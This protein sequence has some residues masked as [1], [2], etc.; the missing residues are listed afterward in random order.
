MRYQKTRGLRTVL[1]A[2]LALGAVFTT[3]GW[4][5][6]APPVTTTAT[7]TYKPLPRETQVAA[8]PEGSYTDVLNMTFPM[9]GGETVRVTDQLDV[10]LQPSKNAEMDQTV[11][12]YDENADPVNSASSGV[13]YTSA[14]GH[15]YQWNVSLLV[16]APPLAPELTYY[17]QLHVYTNDGSD[18]GYDMSVLPPTPGETTYGTWLEVSSSNVAGAQSWNA[19]YCGSHG[20]DSTCLYIGHSGNPAAVSVF[21]GQTASTAPETSCPAGASTLLRCWTAEDDATT[22]DAAA[23]MQITSCPQG[24][25]SCRCKPPTASCQ[26]EHGSDDSARGDA[27]LDVDQLYPD[28]SVCQVNQAYSEQTDD[29]GKVSLTEPYDI[30]NAQHHRPLYFHLTAPV[31][32]TCGGSREFGID[33]RILWTGGNPV[34]LDNGSVNV[35]NSVRETTTT[36]PDVTGDTETAAATAIAT[37]GLTAV[38]AYVMATAPP[39][40][41]LSQNSAG[42]TIEPV[43]SPVQITVSAGQTAVPA[44]LGDTPSKAVHAI[45]QAGLTASVSFIN[46]CVDPGTVQH[47][48]PPAGSEVPLNSQV[49][50]QIT[51]CTINPDGG[52]TR[53]PK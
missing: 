52:P 32:Q 29:N 45:E 14:H 38:P 25:G 1:L 49:D 3:A 18:L 9:T 41:V 7:Y 11:A 24:T 22:I 46:S 17:C 5:P 34:E 19:P 30:S 43:G 13:N 2:A 51:T 53:Q 37:A 6:S 47:Q 27:Y 33:L 35:I 48:D 12:C 31:S 50:I 15:A 4:Q 20:T 28:G 42:G 40:T 21:A 16:S 39:G 23:T 44:V 26:D 36:V 10:S 8:G